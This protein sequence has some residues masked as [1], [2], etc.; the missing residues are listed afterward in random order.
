MTFTATGVAGAATRYVVTS[1]IYSPVAGTSVTVTARLADQ[2]GN[3]VATS[4]IWVTF[5]KTGTGG[6]FVGANPATT[7]ASGTATITFTT[8][9]TVGT[10]HTVTATSTVPSARTGTSPD[11]H[12]ALDIRAMG[13]WAG[14]AGTRGYRGEEEEVVEVSGLEPLTFWLPARRSPS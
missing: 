8:A 13:R 12:D 7:N 11:D 6:A 9:G 3:A 14:R 2:Y 1:S 10:V 4:G 5:T